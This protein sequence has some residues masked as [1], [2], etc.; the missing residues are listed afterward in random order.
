[1]ELFPSAIRRDLD[2][3]TGFAR[4][5]VFRS[6]SRTAGC[7]LRQSGN[8]SVGSD[9]C[10]ISGVEDRPASGKHRR[11]RSGR[12][13]FRRR[14]GRRPEVVSHYRGVLAS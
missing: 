10:A 9:A 7:L 14:S 11:R 2:A 3:I 8:H 12:S 5:A 4:V 6:E 1:M 13:V